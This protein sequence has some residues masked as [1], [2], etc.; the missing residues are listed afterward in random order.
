[1]TL[2]VLGAEFNSVFHIDNKSF[3]LLKREEDMAYLPCLPPDVHV[4]FWDMHREFQEKLPEWIHLY[5]SRWKY[6][7]E[8]QRL[9]EWFELILNK[10]GIDKSPDFVV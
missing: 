4:V 1:M 10:S 7:D 5:G 2:Q 9:Y 8:E 6:I 3:A